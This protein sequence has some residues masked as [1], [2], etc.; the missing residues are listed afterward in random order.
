[1]GVEVT[2]ARAELS[3]D[4]LCAATR[5][6]GVGQQTSF[7][8]MLRPTALTQTCCRN[9]RADTLTSIQPSS[10]LT[11]SKL[12]TNCRTVDLATRLT[13]TLQQPFS[14]GAEGPVS[15]TGVLFAGIA[16]SPL[17]DPLQGII[18]DPPVA[19]QLRYE[20]I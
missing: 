14:R 11:W 5:Q 8:L 3:D 2:P 10:Q 13:N 7:V 20:S 17:Q 15:P 19:V 4:L 6:L 9:Y 12:N 18:H 1:L 16:L